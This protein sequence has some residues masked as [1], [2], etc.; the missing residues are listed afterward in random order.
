L[1]V[2]YN[3]ALGFIAGGAGLLACVWRERTL[4]FAAAGVVLGGITLA[5]Y[6]DCFSGLLFGSASVAIYAIAV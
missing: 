2:K 6:R 5:E 3:T 4:T 1:L